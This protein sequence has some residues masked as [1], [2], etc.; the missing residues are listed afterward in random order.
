MFSHRKSDDKLKGFIEIELSIDT[1]DS[2][3]ILKLNH[4]AEKHGVSIESKKTNT[5]PRE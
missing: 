4:I 3:A 2:L 1:D 5:N